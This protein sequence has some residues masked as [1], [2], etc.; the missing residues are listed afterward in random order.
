MRCDLVVRWVLALMTFAL[1]V[2]FLLVLIGRA[3]ALLT[4]LLFALALMT[5]AFTAFFLLALTG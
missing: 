4:L 2:F 1:A 3:L 5:L